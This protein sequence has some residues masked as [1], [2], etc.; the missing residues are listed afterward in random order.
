MKYD[1]DA[2]GVA[3][4]QETKLE[5]RRIANLFLISSLTLIVLLLQ[6]FARAL[7]VTFLPQPVFLIAGFI[8]LIGW[9]VTFVYGLYVT[10]RAGRWGWLVL[11]AIPLSC[12]PASVAYA[13]I[14]RQEIER[15]VLGERSAG[16]VGH[17]RGG[18]DQ[19]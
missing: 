16:A 4:D 11:C 18:G 17:R 9:S 6:V 1:N 5:L 8:F 15:E 13:W 2:P 3:V 19:S 10:W 14:R 7:H 12:V